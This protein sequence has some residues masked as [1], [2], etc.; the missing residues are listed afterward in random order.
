MKYLKQFLIIIAI[1]FAGEVLHYFIPLPVPASIYGMVLLFAGLCTE[2]IPLSAVKETG[3]F[4]VAMMQIMFIPATVGLID[5][6]DILKD[7][8]PVYLIITF[9]TT[10]AVLLAVGKVVQLGLA[11][12]KS[13][14]GRENA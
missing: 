6:W 13:K 14:E 9:V 1:S 7:R 8:W 3:D 5:S 11:R 12:S 10:M 2:L 4:L